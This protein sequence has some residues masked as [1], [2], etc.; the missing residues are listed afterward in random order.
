[1]YTVILFDFTRCDRTIYAE[2]LNP[3]QGDPMIKSASLPWAGTL[4]VVVMLCFCMSVSA[5]ARRPAASWNFYYFDGSI[6]AAGQPVNKTPFIAVRKH[7]KPVVMT[8]G[9]TPGEVALPSG[10]GAVAGIGYIQSSG[11]K[12]GQG[13]SFLPYP[14]LAVT[15]SSGD[16]IISS[17][18]TDEY[19]YFILILEPG[20]YRIGTAPFAVTVDVKDGITTLVPLRAGKRMVD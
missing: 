13:E 15:A 5:A 18:Q 17:V 11:G 1:M 8:H 3:D 19:G 16:K 2:M 6:F 4:V 10:K 7:F 12:L 20:N 14:G 9:A